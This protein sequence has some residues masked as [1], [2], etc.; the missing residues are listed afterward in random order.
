MTATVP[1]SVDPEG[2]A[3]TPNGAHAYVTNF[4]SG[5]ASVIDTAPP[6]ATT[7]T[8]TPAIASVSSLHLYLFALNATQSSAAEPAAGHVITFKAGS[9]VICTAVTGANGTA[10][11]N[12]LA[13]VLSI[14]LADGYSASFAGTSRYIASTSRAALIG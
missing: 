6:A 3:I 14:V 10:S 13:S 1:V 11:C 12:G 4:G 7:L 9:T 8:S 5:N 2:V